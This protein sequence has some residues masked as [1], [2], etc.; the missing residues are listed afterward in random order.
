MLTLWAMSLL[1]D[2]PD[3]PARAGIIVQHGFARSA[4]NMAGIAGLLADR[5]CLTVR[6][7]IPSFTVRRSLHDQAWLD[8]FGIQVITDV[9]QRAPGM[10]LIGI[11]H[12]AGGAVVAGWSDHLDGL[13][14]LDPVDRHHRVQRCA[15]DPRHPPMRVITADPS[16][17][18]RHGRTVRML[19]AVGCVEAGVTWTRIVG[20]SH[21]DPERVPATGL[22]SDVPDPDLLARLACGSSGSATLVCRWGTAI[23]DDVEA[24][25][26]GASAGWPPG[27]LTS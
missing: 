18:N 26:A 8:D 14:L 3:A 6:P 7:S 27:P 5:G 23:G 20:S 12:S 21:P 11:G 25:I 19:A 22:A 13:L 24:L 4:Q 17:C 9:R 1:W 10:P 16:A 15:A 2:S